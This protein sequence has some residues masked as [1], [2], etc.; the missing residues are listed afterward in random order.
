MKHQLSDLH[1][2]TSEQFMQAINTLP[3]YMTSLNLSNNFLGNRT[4]DELVQ[5]FAALHA[6][7]PSSLISLDLGWNY[8]N[9]KTGAELALA[10]AAL[11][12]V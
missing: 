2:L 11:P 3:T 7:H 1:G 5:A 9:N 6:R 10:F 8:L 12:Q 4:V